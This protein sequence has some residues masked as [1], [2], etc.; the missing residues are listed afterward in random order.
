MGFSFFTS[1][2]GA[3]LLNGIARPGVSTAALLLTAARCGRFLR[4]FPPEIR[5]IS[6]LSFFWFRR[7]IYCSFFCL[8]ICFFP[9]PFELVSCS[10]IVV[11]CEDHV[12]GILAIRILY[13]WKGKG[14]PPTRL[15]HFFGLLPRFHFDY[16]R[17]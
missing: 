13:F 1:R 12:L 15:I 2:A 10:I 6:L 14:H 16:S 17:V 8:P 7:M 3:R 5:P 11:N 9:H 4:R